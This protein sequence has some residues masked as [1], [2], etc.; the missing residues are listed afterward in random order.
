MSSPSG[1]SLR[2][3]AREADWSDEQLIEALGEVALCEFQSL[4]ANA[5]GLPE[6]QIDSGLLP[7]AA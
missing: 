4:I 7:Q 2:L 5:A 6:D 3:S 1:E